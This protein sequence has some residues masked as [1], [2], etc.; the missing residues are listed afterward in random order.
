VN[1]SESSITHVCALPEGE[2]PGFDAPANLREDAIFSLYGIAMTGMDF[3]IRRFMAS[4]RWECVDG[5]WKGDLRMIFDALPES[6]PGGK[7]EHGFDGVEV[8]E[9]DQT[10]LETLVDRWRETIITLCLAHD[11]SA[12]DNAEFA[13]E[14]LLTP[15]ITC[16]GRQL[17]EFWGLLRERLENDERC[18]FFVWKFFRIWEEGILAHAEEV[19]PVELKRELAGRIAQM[20]EAD[21][22]PDLM[23]AITGALQWRSGETL[24]KIEGAIKRGGRARL[25]GRESCLF[26]EVVRPAPLPEGC[27]ETCAHEHAEAVQIVDRV[28]L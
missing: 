15:L 6:G 22:K 16:P 8:I 21:V 27:D 12:V 2:N 19:G 7:Y 14:D 11:K 17:K 24:E 25:K 3:Q 26:L 4:Q 13:M 20:V 1:F 10:A 18:P 23:E 9:M 5:R 28:M